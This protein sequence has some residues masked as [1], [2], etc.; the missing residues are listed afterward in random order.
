[1]SVDFLNGAVVNERSVGSERDL[2]SG[3]SAGKKRSS[4]SLLEAISNFKRS[5]PGGKAGRKFG[6]YGRLDKYSVGADTCLT[7]SSKFAENR[8]FPSH[9][10]SQQ[11]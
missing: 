11:T 3:R 9:M 2:L 5:Y 8:S 4:H 10:N 1:M 7:A 6:I